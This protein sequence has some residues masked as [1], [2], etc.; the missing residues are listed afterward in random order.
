MLAGLVPSEENLFCVLLASLVLVG[1]PWDSLA[2]KGVIPLHLCVQN[3]SSLKCTSHRISHP[4][5]VELIF[6]W[7]SPP[8]KIMFWGRE[9][10]VIQNSAMYSK[11]AESV[12]FV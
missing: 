6:W 7:T 10:D 2:C 12:C 4:N 9:R 8:N 3:A 5:L 11:L 1:N